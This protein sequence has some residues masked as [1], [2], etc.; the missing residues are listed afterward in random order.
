M[1]LI[2]SEVRERNIGALMAIHDLN[3]AARFCD[4][5]IVLQHG[6]IFD[7]GRPAELLTPALIGQVYGV[8]AVIG[9]ESGLPFII[10]VEPVGGER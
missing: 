7:S 10:P 2:R 5:V 3:L 4:R 8:R 1:D 6:R 9:T